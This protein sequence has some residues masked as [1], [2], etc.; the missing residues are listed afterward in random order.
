MVRAK[1]VAHLERLAV[2]VGLDDP[3][4][5]AATVLDLETALAAVSWD[6]VSNRDAEKTYTLMT[7]PAVVSATAPRVA[8][9]CSM[10]GVRIRRSH[11]VQGGQFVAESRNTDLG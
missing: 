4:G 7:W 3:A 8:V 11:A 6:R 5:L 2:L 10:I 1:Y 9:K